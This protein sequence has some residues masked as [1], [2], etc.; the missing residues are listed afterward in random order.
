MAARL[1]VPAG[2]DGLARFRLHPG[3]YLL[4]GE[5]GVVQGEVDV[6]AAGASLEL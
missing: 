6:P 1:R 5:R 2:E 4:V 3:R